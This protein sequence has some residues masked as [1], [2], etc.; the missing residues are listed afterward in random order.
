M[1]RAGFT[2][3]ELLV[4]ITIIATLLAI[5]LPALSA[6]RRQTR[7]VVCDSNLR[8]LAFALTVYDHENGTFPYGFDDSTHGTT[9]PPGGYPG[10]HTHDKMGWWWFHFL[11]KTL[12]ENFDKRSIVWCP[13]R[14]IRDP[15]PKA[16]VL[17]G[18][19]GVNR[20]ICKDAPGITGIIGG[21]FVGT[22]LSLNQIHSPA[23]TL[24]ITDS[25]Y[26]LIS[27]RGVTNAPGQPF[28]NTRRE[29][30]FYAPGLAINKERI[31]EGTISQSCERDAIDGRHPNK[32]VNVGFADGHLARLKA[33][34]LLV[35]EIDGNYSNRSPLWLPK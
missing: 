3:I 18:N 20:S 30:A 25:G 15:F 35:E 16:N 22:P 23:E 12:G 14:C 24:F 6:S 33:D 13:A 7:T 34:D 11:T 2:L 4:A 21:E 5:L 31:L 32:T 1:R 9:R 27:W 28:E 17:C 26:S 29:G 8:Q 19:Y 10:T